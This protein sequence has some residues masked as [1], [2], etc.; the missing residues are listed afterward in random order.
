MVATLVNNTRNHSIDINITRN[1]QPI[2]LERSQR[3]HL[4]SHHRQLDELF[5]GGSR[6]FSNTPTAV[7]A[8]DGV[9][10]DDTLSNDFINPQPT[11]INL[12]ASFLCLPGGGE[13]HIAL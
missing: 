3:H 2:G 9:L 5:A 1:S 6:S 10:F 4:G 13:Q 8:G 11:N 12:T 7:I